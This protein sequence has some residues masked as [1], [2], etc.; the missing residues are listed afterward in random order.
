MYSQ[1]NSLE[2]NK[3]FEVNPFFS[4]QVRNDK[5]D[6]W[7]ELF[8][9][10]VR[11]G[12]QQTPYVNSAMVKLDFDD[13][14]ELR[15]T[16]RVS[17][18]ANFE[19]RPSSYKI[20]AI[21][22]GR[23]TIRFKLKQGIENSPKL[24]VRINNNWETACLHI[25]SNPIEEKI[26][27]CEENIYRVKEGEEIPLYLPQGKDTYYF[28]SGI[29]YLPRGIWLEHDLQ[30]K[31]HVNK[32]IIEPNIIQL[33]DYS[34]GMEAVIS[35]KFIIESKK[36]EH[37]KY[38]ILYDGR[39]NKAVG[40]LELEIPETEVRFVRIR[41]FGSNEN[42]L[43]FSNALKKFRVFDKDGGEELT[44]KA[45]TRAAMPCMLKGNGI[46]DSGYGNWHAAESF[47]LC[48][49]HYKIYMEN[50]AVVRG[51]V[52]SDGVNDIKI[53]GRGILDC[54]GL[55]HFFENAGEDRTGAIWL[56]SGKNLEVEGITV[57]DP[58]M[59]SIV[60]NYGEN[61]KIKNVNLIASALN[62][63]G[64]HFSGSKNVFIEN[65][66]IRTC[67]DLLV[68]YHYGK[69]ENIRIKHCV[70]WSDDGHA[71][72]FGL[73]SVQNAGIKDVKVE[74]C[75][76][77]DHRAAWDYQ[78]FSGAIKLWPNG[79]NLMEDIV[80]DTIYIDSFQMPEIA[81]VFQLTT[82][83]RFEGEG[84]GILKNILLK[85]IFYNG[86]G[87]R[88]SLI[89]GVDEKFSVSEVKIQNYYRNDVKVEDTEAGHIT[90]K[91]FV[92]ALQIQ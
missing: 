12:H 86:E 2:K 1:L 8:V 48:E 38:E 40:I 52:A 32:F 36:T 62:A 76:I 91:G 19:I 80:F 54:S 64:I 10:N 73:G 75:N 59:W 15:V 70:L 44:E 16:Y 79:G 24:V 57:L 21:R 41:M 4:V 28:E 49:D 90:V 51:A 43:R 17:D 14:V 26:D 11:I 69:A 9:Y 35:Q 29:H 87:E 31:Y 23:R 85:N 74:N 77:L 33:K 66:F 7:E 84:N 60:L 81:S 71:F 61:I 39:N 72:L 47:F 20:E 37:D 58:P 3:M 13:C 78:K 55:E 46:S 63:D 42:G 30:K 18:I 5:E 67:D 25:L 82:K 22:D 53:Y 50:G 92:K 27:K 65:C 68:M 83:E 89:H 45:I 34:D 88:N 6:M 56:T